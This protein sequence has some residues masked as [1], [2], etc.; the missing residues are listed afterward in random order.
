MRILSPENVFCK[1]QRTLIAA[2]QA[3]RIV[4]DLGHG[5]GYD[6]PAPPITAPQNKSLAISGERRRTASSHGKFQRRMEKNKTRK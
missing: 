1:G 5:P 4:R 6:Q 3:A 2:Y